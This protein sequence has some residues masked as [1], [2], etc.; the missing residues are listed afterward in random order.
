MGRFANGP[1]VVYWHGNETQEEKT[2]RKWENGKGNRDTLN[3]PKN[4]SILRSCDTGSSINWSPF[5]TRSCSREN[6]SSHRCICRWYI[7][8][9]NGRYASLT[10]PF[11]SMASSSNVLH[12]RGRM[13]CQRTR[14]WC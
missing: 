14:L 7:D 9:V 10:V 1:L 8:I 12:W 6:T 5:T 11:G 3:I 2:I 4:V 13:K